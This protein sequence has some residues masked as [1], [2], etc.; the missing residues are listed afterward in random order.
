MHSP[1]THLASSE[2]NARQYGESVI[3]YLDLH[4]HYTPSTSAALLL[5]VNYTPNTIP[6]FHVLERLVDAH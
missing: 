4:L 1:L 5:H 6:L 2:T 3:A